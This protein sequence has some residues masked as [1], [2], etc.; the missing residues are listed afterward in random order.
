[1]AAQKQAQ[2]SQD[3]SD[4]Y[5]EPRPLHGVNYAWT[6]KEQEGAFG[7]LPAR[8]GRLSCDHVQP[9]QRHQE[10]AGRQGSGESHPGPD[11]QHATAAGILRLLNPLCRR[12]AR[13]NCFCH[14]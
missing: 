2:T 6:P 13:C 10:P 12:H 11:R 4:R 8:L 7:S 3:Q 14:R 5:K 1:M 9:L